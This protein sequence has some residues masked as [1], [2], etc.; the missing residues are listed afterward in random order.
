MSLERLEI[1][2]PQRLQ[3]AGHI[4]QVDRD[5][6]PAAARSGNWRPCKLERSVGHRKL[7]AVEQRGAAEGERDVLELDEGRGDVALAPRSHALHP[8]DRLVEF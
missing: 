3:L 6:M 7:D 8:P 4:A 5:R 2:H 1:T